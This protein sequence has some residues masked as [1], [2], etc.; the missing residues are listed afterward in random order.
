MV[1]GRKRRVTEGAQPQS[2]NSENARL[3]LALAREGRLLF[4]GVVAILLIG[5]GIGTFIFFRHLAYGDLVAARQL[6]AQVQD[7]D[8]AQ[9]KLVNEQNIKMNT[10][11]TELANTKADLEA[12]R[13]EKDKYDIPPNESRIIAD[14]KLTVGLVGSPAIDSLTLSINGKPQ[15]AV[16]GQVI[17]VA[18]DPSTNCQVKVQSFSMVKA[19]VNA[20]CAA[21]K[22]Q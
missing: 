11:E 21:A 18:P 7:D 12:V 16:A 4:L 17:D 13:P 19:T 3:R 10:L 22:P 8:E 14:G 6:I 1:L 2:W 15:S 5:G 20:A 9:R